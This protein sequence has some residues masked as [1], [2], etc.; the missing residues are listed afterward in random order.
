MSSKKNDWG[1][2]FTEEPFD[3][4]GTIKTS[5]NDSETKAVGWTKVVKPAPTKNQKLIWMETSKEGSEQN[6]RPLWAHETLKKEQETKKD[7]LPWNSKSTTKSKNVSSEVSKEQVSWVSDMS[8]SYDN[9]TNV[10]SWNKISSKSSTRNKQRIS[11]SSNTRSGRHSSNSKQQSRRDDK[12][13]ILPEL[14]ELEKPEKK[15]FRAIPIIPTKEELFAKRPKDL[16]VNKLDEPYENVDEYLSTHCRL[17]REDCMRPL[18]EGIQKLRRI[19]NGRK[20]KTGDNDDEDGEAVEYADDEAEMQEELSDIRVYE[21]IQI[22]GITFANM[23]IVHR[24]SFRTK[25]GE[26]ITWSQSKR[27]IS[28]TLVV[29]T[30]DNFENMVVGTVVNRSLDLLTQPSDLQIDVLLSGETFHYN[31]PTNYIMVECTS[32]YFEAYRH[33]QKVLQELD[34]E[35]LP[36][37]SHFMGHDRDKETPPPQYLLKRQPVYEFKNLEAIKNLEKSNG[38]TMIDIKDS[39]PSYDQLDT[40]LH[41]SQYEAIWRMLTHCVALIQGPPGTGKTYVGLSAIR[42]LLENTSGLIIIACQTNHALDQFLEGIQEF[43][44]DIIRL[45][46]RSK[47]EKIIPRTLYNISRALKDTEQPNNKA[48]RQLMKER[49]FI[50]GKMKQLCEEISNPCI[51]LDFIKEQE[52]LNDE[53]LTSLQQDDWVTSQDY[54]TVDESNRDF[55]REWL[56]PV[57]RIHSSKHDALEHQLAQMDLEGRIVTEE[58]DDTEV[59][60]ELLETI[61]AE[62]QDGLLRDENQKLYGDF[63]HLRSEEYVED[64]NEFFTDNELKEFESTDDVWTIPENARAVIHNKWKRKKMQKAQKELENLSFKY[65]EICAKIKKERMRE[66]IL[67]LQGARVVGM[68]TTAAAKNH[69]LLVNLKPKIIMLEEAAETLEAHIIT[70][71][72]PSTE[73]LILIGDHEQLR[74]ST[75]VYEM[76]G[77]HKLDVS[78]FE[79]LTGFL[80]FTRLSEQRRMRPIIRQLLTPIYGT[81]I[82]DAPNVHEYPDV[83]G[84]TENLFFINHE[85][86][87]KNVHDS[88]TK[89]NEHEA[90]M[91][92]KLAGYLVK[93]GYES[94]QITILCMY[95]GQRERIKKLLREEASKSVDSIRSIKVASVDGFQGEEN[96]IIL[97]SL[98]RSSPQRGQLAEKSALWLKV[99]MILEGMKKIGKRLKLICPKHSTRIEPV[100]TSVEWAGEFP[101]DG[102]CFKKCGELMDCGHLCPRGCHIDSHDRVACREPCLRTLPCGH[103]CKKECRRPCGP[104]DVPVEIN[105]KCGHKREIACQMLNEYKCSDKCGKK[106]RCGHQASVF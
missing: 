97:L 40:S 43:E 73:H 50:E 106:L 26:R 25:Y 2:Q 72:T 1:Q 8:E 57:I 86:E 33:V 13:P 42:L 88:K 12:G 44:P 34:P 79:R 58:N 31:W 84:M 98:V 102:G 91:C 82:E 51:S 10:N 67:I 85:E 75:A 96:D 81:E 36:F 11:S 77:K 52:L 87:E 65:A 19:N 28:G 41:M 61:E 92:A 24:I 71:L 100:I 55:I 3:A 93:M 103:P 70:A 38:T 64:E 9:S 4:W 101:P 95:T 90:T 63:V 14:I 37:K 6:E 99:L 46:S 22:V 53:Q 60:E 5:T 78:L 104:C 62:F 48:R 27:L 56:E 32:A 80:P 83:I 59:D 89:I 23:G 94:S 15:G 54:M 74:P 21:H 20:Q 76:A 69:D 16:P 66:D 39:W 47:S 35:T 30:N 105:P 29:F 45:G 68:T 7:E 49:R 17:L 18:R